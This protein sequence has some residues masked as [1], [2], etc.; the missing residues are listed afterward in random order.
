MLVSISNTAKCLQTVSLET[1][2]KRD[3]GIGVCRLQILYK[4]G[5][6]E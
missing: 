5:V 3:P 1:L 2:L 4:M 6:L